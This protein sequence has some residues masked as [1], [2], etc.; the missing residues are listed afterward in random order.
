MRD[1][2]ELEIAGTPGSFLDRF[3][4]FRLRRFTETG[5]FRHPARLASLVELLD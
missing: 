4:N 5:Q 3:A 2:A 1:L